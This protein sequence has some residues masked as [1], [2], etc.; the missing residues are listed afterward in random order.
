MNEEYV[1]VESTHAGPEAVRRLEDRV[2]G[3][4]RKIEGWKIATVG[5]MVVGFIL[6]V[7]RGVT[8]VVVSGEN[9]TV[10]LPKD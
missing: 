3:L 10:N 8:V 7:R 9:N 6:A 1:S 2:A 5:L 4:E